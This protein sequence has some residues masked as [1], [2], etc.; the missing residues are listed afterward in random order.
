MIYDPLGSCVRMFSSSPGSTLSPVSDHPSALTSRNHP[1]LTP[2]SLQQ[3]LQKQ[4]CM[5][6]L[7]LCAWRDSPLRYMCLGAR[8]SQHARCLKSHIMPLRPPHRSI[9]A[10]AIDN[11]MPYPTIS[12]YNTEQCRSMPYRSTPAVCRQPHTLPHHTKTPYIAYLPSLPTIPFISTA[13]VILTVEG[14][15]VPSVADSSVAWQRNTNE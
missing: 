8:R 9:A 6:L 13:P 15:G 2:R 7:I 12:Y 10:V 3:N 1:H 14:S 5:I 11:P 4:D